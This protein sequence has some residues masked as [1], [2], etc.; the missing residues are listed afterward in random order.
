[1]K[2]KKYRTAGSKSRYKYLYRQIYRM[3]AWNRLCIVCGCNRECL[4]R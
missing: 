3:E 2:I 1:M 4:I